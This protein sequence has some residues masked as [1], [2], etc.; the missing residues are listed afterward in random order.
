[1]LEVKVRDDLTDDDTVVK[2]EK[3]DAIQLIDNLVFD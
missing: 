1:M 2:D 3:G